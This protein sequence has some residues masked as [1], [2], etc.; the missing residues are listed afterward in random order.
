MPTSPHALET[1]L[2]AAYE[3][4]VVEL[5]RIESPEIAENNP[6]EVWVE[7]T[8][9]NTIKLRLLKPSSVAIVV[10]HLSPWSLG[11]QPLQ[12]YL[13]TRRV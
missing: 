13:W 8:A 11:T 10:A 2:N 9:G 7:D 1:T 12:F 5:N 6:S 3:S 4:G